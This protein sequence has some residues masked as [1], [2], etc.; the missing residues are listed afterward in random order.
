MPN[1]QAQAAIEANPT[2]APFTPERTAGTEGTE[3]VS[4]QTPTEG[5]PAAATGGDGLLAG[6]TS[7]DDIL[8]LTAHLKPGGVADPNAS[9]GVMLKD[10]P[11]VEEAAIH[12]EQA[13]AALTGEQPLPTRI[14]IGS[15]SD[16]R[17]RLILALSNRTPRPRKS[18][19]G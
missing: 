15:L 6:V 16:E 2:A 8:A 19:A 9:T 17:K 4:T 5:S 3:T 1:E 13:E 10:Y 12:P 18:F 7:I 11:A 14:R